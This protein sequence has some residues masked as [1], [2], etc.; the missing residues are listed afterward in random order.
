MFDGGIGGMGRADMRNPNSIGILPDTIGLTDGRSR[1]GVLP[2]AEWKFSTEE[3]L[4][5]GFDIVGEV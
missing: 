5:E 2:K 3:L 1:R 4:L